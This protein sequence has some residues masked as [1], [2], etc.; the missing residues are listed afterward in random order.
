[1]YRC[2]LCGALSKPGQR[3]IHIIV[4][5]RPVSYPARANSQA[6]VKRND[7]TKRK[8]WRSDPGG[9]GN[10]IVDQALVCRVC[11]SAHTTSAVEPSAFEPS[12]AEAGMPDEIGAH[13]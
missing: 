12:A 3:A 1:M 11:A 2:E 6:P 5:T 13:D 7:R 9:T 8:R 10:E 4:K